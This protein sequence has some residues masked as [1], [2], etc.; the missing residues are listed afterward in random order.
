MIEEWKKA[1]VAGV[2][3]FQGHIQRKNNHQ[4]AADS[5]QITLYVDTSI[6][7]I[8]MRLSE[9]TGANLE[10]KERHKVRPEWQRK[11]C[12]EHCPEAHIHVNEQF[13]IPPT[14]RWSVTGA[15]LAIVLWN[16][17]PYMT[18][19]RE[20]WEWALAQC[21]SQMKLTGRGSAAVSEAAKRLHS[22]GWELPPVMQQLVPKALE[23]AG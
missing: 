7:E 8:V 1:W 16:L 2:L 12:E 5:Q 21:L 23:A 9:M 10:M 18:T 14:G 22:L 19:K 3:D 13:A 17:L 15:A 11:G 4:R 6:D 20:P